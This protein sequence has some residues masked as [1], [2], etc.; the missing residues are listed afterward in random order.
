MFGLPL[1]YCIFF[2]RRLRSHYLFLKTRTCFP[3][4]SYMFLKKHVHVFLQRS[5]WFIGIL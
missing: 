4:F 2:Q 1:G 5:V 3:E